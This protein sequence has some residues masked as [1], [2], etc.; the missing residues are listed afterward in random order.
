MRCVDRIKEMQSMKKLVFASLAAL[1]AVTLVATTVFAG[2]QLTQLQ[3]GEEESQAPEELSSV[4]TQSPSSPEP[5]VLEPEPQGAEE[6][7]LRDPSYIDPS[8]CFFAYPDRVFN[9]GETVETWYREHTGPNPEDVIELPYTMTVTGVRSS[10]EIAP[11]TYSDFSTYG[12]VGQ[13]AQEDQNGTLHG[14]V[15]Y[16]FV[17]MTIHNQSDQKLELYLNN[18]YLMT[19]PENEDWL[20]YDT[21]RLLDNW[22]YP[23]ASGSYFLYEFEPGE[24][25]QFT[26]GYLID[27][28]YIDRPD[29]VV[30]IGGPGANWDDGTERFVRLNQ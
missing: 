14:D 26:L 30:S 22:Q 29:L 1:A 7:D 9:K 24:E 5:S 19:L 23:P 25:S 2:T 10:K 21:P 16:L 27:D 17:E 28:D 4:L 12:L 15:S 18:S 8:G 11:Y 13:E 6:I 20:H 3:K